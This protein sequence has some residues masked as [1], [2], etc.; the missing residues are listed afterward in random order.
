MHI[1]TIVFYGHRKTGRYCMKFKTID[2]TIE[3]I[4]VMTPDYIEK[5]FGKFGKP[6]IKQQLIIS[7]KKRDEIVK[8]RSLVVDDI[9][10]PADVI[11][12]KCEEIPADSSIKDDPEKVLPLSYIDTQITD[13]L[14]GEM[15]A[16]PF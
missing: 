8:N 5:T 1:D 4:V 14:I 9:S 16:V 7:N 15:M 6:T 3:S 11:D 12:E 2:G 10:L 13:S